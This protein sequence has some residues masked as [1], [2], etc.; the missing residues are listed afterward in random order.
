[1]KWKPGAVM[2]DGLFIVQN[3][4][5]YG[6]DFARNCRI[7]VKRK[8]RCKQDSSQGYSDFVVVV[9]FNGITLFQRLKH[10]KKLHSCGRRTF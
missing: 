4:R 10:L 6:R 7:Y 5:R 3:L 1:M 2:W 9:V 8:D